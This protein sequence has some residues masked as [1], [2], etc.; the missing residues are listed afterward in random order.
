MGTRAMHWRSPPKGAHQTS[1]NN[2][3]EIKSLTKSQLLF[4]N[5]KKKRLKVD[6]GPPWQEYIIYFC[7]LSANERFPKIF[8][9][10]IEI[11]QFLW[12]P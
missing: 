11:I 8:S 9:P 1:K 6:C 3:N 4:D 2:A 5:R 7:I 10:G 12:G